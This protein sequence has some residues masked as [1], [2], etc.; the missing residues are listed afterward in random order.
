MSW[1]LGFISMVSLAVAMLPPGVAVV[2]V[3][4]SLL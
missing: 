3:A 2:D 1:L 4:Y